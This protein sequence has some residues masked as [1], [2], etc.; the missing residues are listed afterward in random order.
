[1]KWEVEKL[2]I[3]EYHI[4]RDEGLDRIY[5][6]TVRLWRGRDG[7]VLSIKIGYGSWEIELTSTVFSIL[8]ELDKRG[9]INLKELIG[10][11]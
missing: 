7:K 9:I 5:S 6:Y 10:S 2:P 8:R 11:C 3:E 4:I 1:M